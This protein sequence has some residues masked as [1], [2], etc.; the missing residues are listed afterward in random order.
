MSTYVL[1]LTMGNPANSSS[2]DAKAGRFNSSSV[3]PNSK[4]WFQLN[5]NNLWPTPQPGQQV[6][7]TSNP[8]NNFLQTPF[9]DAQAFNCNLADNMYVRV[10]PDSSW[11][12]PPD[13]VTLSVNFG[14]TDAVHHGGDTI[15]SPFVVS[16][17][18]VSTSVNVPATAF[19][20]FSASP[21]SFINDWI[22]Y[23]GPATQNA[24]NNAS[25]A[26]G[27]ATSLRTYSFIVAA[28]AFYSSNPPSS[29]TV[30]GNYGHDPQMIVIG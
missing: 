26:S 2:T 24:L 11:G 17:P 25:I 5:P 10:A 30:A 29:L 14:R 13:L 4:V 16:V 27:G 6:T 28:V 1:N 15:P 22:I 9:P 23:L 12:A 19:S 18:S 21:T 20:L 8:T 7:M 3:D